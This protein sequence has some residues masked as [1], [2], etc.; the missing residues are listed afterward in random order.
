MA[1]VNS[2]AS[3]KQI[4]SDKYHDA[5]YSVFGEKY[6]KYRQLWNTAIKEDLEIDFPLHI[7]FELANSCNYKCSFCPYSLKPSMR[8][9]GFNVSGSKM[10][11]INLVE[12]ILREAN[13]RL[14]AVELGYNTEPLLHPQAL[15]IAALCSQYGVLDIRM[16]TNGSL[17]GNFNFKDIIESGIT[18]LQVS[19]DAV[20]SS[21]YKKA[22]NSEN[23]SKVVDNI[24][25]FVRS[26]DEMG[27]KLPRI[28]I[29]YVKTPENAP[30]AQLFISQWN[31][32]ADIIGIQDLLVYP[33]SDL[34]VG[35]GNFVGRDMDN[36]ESCYMPKVR[37]SIRS[38]GTV[39]P[40]CNVPGMKLKVGDL[41][42]KTVQQVWLSPS[43][44]ALRT[45]HYSEAWKKN[46]ICRECIANTYA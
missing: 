6:V 30:N 10:I 46:K 13:G 38:D 2:S 41:N 37:L 31:E 25:S 32:I 28:R 4:V 9:R 43:M 17:L 27:S 15:K 21:S 11:D 12:K 40:C 7:D 22:R 24:K 8:P 1:L 5:L 42:K 29:T 14:Y 39:H 36:T 23:Y 34:A 20:D 35:T 33:D 44:K 18:Q 45:S 3:V 26:R 19:V 16:G